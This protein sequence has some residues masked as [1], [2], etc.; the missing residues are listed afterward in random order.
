MDEGMKEQPFDRS[1]QEV[2]DAIAMSAARING[3]P[4]R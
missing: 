4:T 2:G 1:V 3:R